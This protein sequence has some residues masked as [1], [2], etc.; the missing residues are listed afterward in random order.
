VLIPGDSCVWVA[1]SV[2]VVTAQ[3]ANDASDTYGD[4]TA[5]VRIHSGNEPHEEMD[6]RAI[7]CFDQALQDVG[8]TTA[9][10]VRRVLLDYFARGDDDDNVPIPRV[11]R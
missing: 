2:P 1:Q 5:V 3:S 6:Q 8:L 11:G 10:P 4:E 7:A 9:D